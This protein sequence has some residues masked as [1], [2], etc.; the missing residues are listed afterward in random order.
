MI[1]QQ[2]GECEKNADR[3]VH[4]EISRRELSNSNSAILLNK[5]TQGYGVNK[6]RVV[7]E[8]GE[9]INGGVIICFPYWG[10]RNV[11]TKGKPKPPFFVVLSP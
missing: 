8:F 1:S 3:R 9:T 11:S 10:R 4:V 2:R 7:Y 5:F 6:G